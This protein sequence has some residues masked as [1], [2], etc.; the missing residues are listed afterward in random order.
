MADSEDAA[1]VDLSSH[2]RYR[3]AE[4]DELDQLAHNLEVVA[5]YL[6][7]NGDEEQ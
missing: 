1:V 7:P 2:P 5:A 3:H 6:D 4:W